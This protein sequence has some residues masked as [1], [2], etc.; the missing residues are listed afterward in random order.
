MWEQQIHIPQFGQMRLYVHTFSDAFW[1]GYVWKEQGGKLWLKRKNQLITKKLLSWAEKEKL[2]EI[3]SECYEV[4]EVEC[5]KENIDDLIVDI[6]EEDSKV[7]IELANT[8]HACRG[9]AL[10]LAIYKILHPEQD[11]RSH[12][13]EYERFFGKRRWS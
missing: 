8:K 5:K 11:I 3:L 13:A 7:I 4:A 12:K 1:E 10:T 9:A 2:T 6:G